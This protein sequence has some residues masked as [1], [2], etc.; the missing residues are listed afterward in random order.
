MVQKLTVR[1]DATGLYGNY[2][3]TVESLGAASAG[4]IPALDDTGRHHVS[5]MPVGFGADVYT[6]T[7]S[8]ALSAGDFV[9]SFSDSG[10]FSVRKADNSNGRPAHGFVLTAYTAATTATVQ[11]LGETNTAL[12]GLTIGATYHLGTAGG[13]IDTPLSNDDTGK[14]GQVLGFATSATE[15]IT[16]P[17]LPTVL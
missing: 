2:T 6:A 8:E 14:I 11:L 17:G 9:N 15:L 12:T 1:D 10:V 16:Q 3:P 13:V 7:A 4:K 5:T